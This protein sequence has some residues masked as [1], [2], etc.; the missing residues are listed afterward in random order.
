MGAWWSKKVVEGEVAAVGNMFG[1]PGRCNA[2][3]TLV[4]E[5]KG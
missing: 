1:Q 2:A 5:Q 4:G 3:Q